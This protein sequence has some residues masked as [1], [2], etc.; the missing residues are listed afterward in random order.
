MR[1]GPEA[2]EPGTALPALIESYRETVARLGYRDNLAQRAVLE[3]LQRLARDLE[4]AGPVRAGALAWLRGRRAAVQGLYLWGGVGR[5]KTFLVDLFFE[6]LPFGDRQR[7]HFHRL[8]RTVH[9]ALKRRPGADPLPG[10]ARDFARRARLL[11]IDEFFVSDIADAM[12]LGRWLG[13]LVDAGVTVVATSNAHPDELYRGGL[14]RD[15]FVPAIRRIKNHM[16]VV[17]LETGTDFRLRALE[18]AELYHWPLDEGAEDSLAR[19]FQSLAPEAGQTGAV[20]EVNGRELRTVCHADG[21][22]WFTFAGLCRGPRSADDYVELAREHH[23]LLVSDVPV[24]SDDDRDAARRF[25]ALVDECYDR[26]VK[27]ILAAEAPPESLYT[28]KRLA[29]EFQRTTSRVVEMQ[30]HDYLERRHRP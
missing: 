13:S 25:I 15:R 12:I 19:S 8:M 16:A 21:V 14:Q 6:S 22:A 23:S 27:L 17:E 4:A 26:N 9:D 1:R 10:I 24:M 5:G 2:S 30:S 3:R 28:G 18:R 11:C 29:F 20:L 7:L